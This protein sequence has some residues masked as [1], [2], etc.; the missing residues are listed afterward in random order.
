MEAPRWGKVI[1]KGRSPE[2]SLKV[3]IRA[4]LEPQEDGGRLSGQHK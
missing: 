1:L 4:T 2:T 3:G